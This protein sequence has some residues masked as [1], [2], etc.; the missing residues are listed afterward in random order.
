MRIMLKSKI[1][2]IKVTDVNAN[3]HGSI[4][5]DAKLL[6]RADILEYEQVHVLDITNGARFETYIIKGG[7]DECCVN[8]AAAKLVEFGDT[9]IILAYGIYDSVARYHKPKIVTMEL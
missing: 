2:G 3:Y 5:I 7:K 1:H 8:G 9:L 6:R 4:T